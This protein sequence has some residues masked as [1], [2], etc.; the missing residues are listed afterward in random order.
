MKFNRLNV[1][2]GF[3]NNNI[4]FEEFVKSYFLKGFDFGCLTF[5]DSSVV[6]NN[7]ETKKEFNV[8]KISFFDKKNNCECLF[9]ASLDKSNME[10]S[11]Y[12]IN[13]RP[14]EKIELYNDIKGNLNIYFS[15]KEKEEIDSLL[16]ANEIET[17]K[18]KRI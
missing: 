3:T 15:Q 6:V 12:I 8:R 17:K 7:I 11:F 14:S 9:A 4:E 10:A 1:I 5:I 18:R 13:C 16:G 2:D